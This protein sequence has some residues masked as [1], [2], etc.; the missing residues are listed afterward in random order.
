M[1]NLGADE[2][3]SVE[4]HLANTDATA[5]NIDAGPLCAKVPLPRWNVDA[6]PIDQ[7]IHCQ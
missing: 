1:R 7:H 3:T 4:N 6:P 5:N 2:Y